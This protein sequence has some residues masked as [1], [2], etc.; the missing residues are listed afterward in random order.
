MRLRHWRWRPRVGMALVSAAIVLLSGYPLAQLLYQSLFGEGRLDLRPYVQLF[1]GESA[2]ALGHTLTVSVVAAAAALVFG[3]S[4]ALLTQR[5]D[6]PCRRALTVVV[7]L[8]LLT[9]PFVQAVAWIEAY[10]RG[11]L[12]FHWWGLSAD[13]LQG[14]AGIA[15]LLAVQ[16]YPLVFLLV[17]AQLAGQRGVELEEAARSAGAGQWRVCLDVTLP[18]L[19]P[20]FIGT[21]L[22]ALI[23]SAADFGIP[24]ALGI[25]AGYTVVTTLIYRRL[26][27]PGGPG[28]LSEMVALAAL[29]ALVAVAAM[30]I[31]TRLTPRTGGAPALSRR[32]GGSSA[33]LRLQAWRWPATAALA[34]FFAITALV[35]IFGLL[36]QAFAPA[37]IPSID[38]TT[39]TPVHF[40]A[41]LARGGL[42]ALAVSMSLA[43]AAGAIVMAGGIAVATV[44]RYGGR[45]VRFIEGLAALPFA[46]PGSV[47][48][49][50]VIL[51]WQRW[52]YGT[53]TI[54]LLAYVSR[55]AILGI[56]SVS[57][58]MAGLPKELF[59]AARSA[60][61][62]SWRVALDIQRPL[63]QPALLASFGLVFLLSVHE[64]TIS[65]LLY[66]PQ[67]ATIAVQVLNAQQSGDVPVTAA[68][69]VIITAITLAI[70]LPVAVSG[71]LRR[72]LGAELSA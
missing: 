11:G 5:S 56:R 55:F 48:A 14:P 45:T 37:F 47:V 61:A 9:P 59:D 28:A 68:L 19:V 6:M 66:T 50:S 49:V 34:A 32:V 67:T 44:D 30:L 64:L 22:I 21:G 35:P 8:P 3:A 40:E 63:V 31:A 53:F 2:A 46:L 69:A 13:W 12:L 51:A 4:T 18:R 57:A 17:S 72:L 70:A 33:S 39:W 38:P 29:L 52:L 15:T 25:P 62:P 42:R 54:I 71:S 60:G 36:L 41:A 65:S 1:S 27:L 7:L 43:A 58:S 24:A 26:S 10:A 16:T 23:G 20:M